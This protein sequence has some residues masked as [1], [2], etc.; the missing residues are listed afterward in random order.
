MAENW[1]QVGNCLTCNSPVYRHSERKFPSCEH[2]HAAEG[3]TRPTRASASERKRW[4]KVDAIHEGA[5]GG[6]RRGPPSA[7]ARRHPRVRRGRRRGPMAPGIL[8]PLSIA[9]VRAVAAVGSSRGISADRRPDERLASPRHAPSPNRLRRNAAARACQL[10]GPQ[11]VPAWRARAA[12]QPRRRR[13]RSR[14]AP[15]S[16]PKAF[17]G[18][19]GARRAGDTA[20]RDDR[21]AAEAGAADLRPFRRADVGLR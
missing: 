11:L 2:P 6:S 4:E 17:R 21:A 9:L 16:A 3:S 18:R 14:D 19:G 8:S 20:E 5:G 7:G 12:R 13:S 1:T 15:R 10:M